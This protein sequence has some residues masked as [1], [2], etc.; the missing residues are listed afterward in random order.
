M[1][2]KVSRRQ[3]ILALK[4]EPLY[5]GA[6]IHVPDKDDGSISD[7]RGRGGIQN[8]QFDN[9]LGCAMCAVGS[10]LSCGVNPEKFKTFDSLRKLNQVGQRIIKHATM[11]DLTSYEDKECLINGQDETTRRL[12][13]AARKEVKATP[14][15]ALSSLFEALMDKEEMVTSQGLANYKAR[16]VLV[17]F[18][19]KNFPATLVI[20][21]KAK[22]KY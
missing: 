17:N 2:M 16:R 6:F 19:K 15:S 22:D 7:M 21:T 9:Q 1:K 11:R 10:I 8:P 4:R 18:V 14:L 5:A 13:A 20:D 12:V 3:V